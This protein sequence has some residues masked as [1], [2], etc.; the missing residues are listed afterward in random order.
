MPVAV[1]LALFVFWLVMAYRQFQHGDLALAG[2]FLVV[3]IVLTA[4]RYRAARRRAEQ[5]STSTKQ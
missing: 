5:L 1:T 2:V 4:Y 3:G